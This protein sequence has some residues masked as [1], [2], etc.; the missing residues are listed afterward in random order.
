M[1]MP[2]IPVT[3]SG[4]VVS[5]GAR[6]S[7]HSTKLTTSR[8]LGIVVLA[9][10]V[11]NSGGVKLT[12]NYYI[13]F[14][15]WYL[16]L[17]QIF[18]AGIESQGLRKLDWSPV[19]TVLP[20][21]LGFIGFNY[22]LNY[23]GQSLVEYLVLLSYIVTATLVLVLYGGKGDTFAIDLHH[24]LRPFLFFSF[25][26]FLA[27]FVIKGHLTPVTLGTNE[28][29]TFHRVLFYQPRETI[30]FI[31][32]NQGVFWEPGVLQVYM[33]LMFFLSVFVLRDRRYALLA[34]LSV[35]T[36]VSTMGYLLLFIQVCVWGMRVFRRSIGG[37]ILG[38]LIVGTLAAVAYINIADKVVGANKRSASARMYDLRSSMSIVRES[39]L[40]GIGL[41]AS[42]HAEQMFKYGARDTELSI[43]ELRAHGNSNSLAYAAASLGI[44]MFG[45]LLI[46]LSKTALI[47]EKK[48]VFLLVV[49]GSVSS[50]PLLMTPFFVLIVLSGVHAI[51]GKPR[52][53]AAAGERE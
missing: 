11:F 35:L 26:S 5:V 7:A 8:V 50:E 17:L 6:E 13:T 20:L 16:L 51:V 10:L 22:L 46:A 18:V 15:C 28:L 24:A 1:T 29:V 25:A 36:T 39:P 44:P 37:I 31:L 27:Q 12:N 41:S 33:N 14:A 3:P 34:A 47:A 53:H 52:E 32:R 38:M 4:A 30:P 9:L 40:T 23:E 19:A 2:V 42:K 45:I 49:L 43:R 21:A 48:W